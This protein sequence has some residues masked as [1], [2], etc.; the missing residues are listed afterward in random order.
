V[1]DE[2]IQTVKH[3]PY[4]TNIIQYTRD[5]KLF[6]SIREK[7]MDAQYD[8][9]LDLQNNHRS[10][11]LL[12]P[13]KSKTRRF[14]KHDFEKW[15]LVNLKIN[16]MYNFPPIPVRYSKVLPKLKLDDQGLDLFLPEN[17]K[18]DLDPKEKYIGFCPASKHYT[19][20]WPYDYFEELGEILSLHKYRIV[21][22]GGRNDKGICDLIAS[23]IPGSIN[24]CNDNELY[25]TA[26]NMK[27]CHAII[28]NDSGLM[29]V[30]TAIKVPVVAIFGSTVT[31]FGFT[32]YKAKSDVV[33]VENLKCRPC[34]HIGRN[35]CPQ[36]HFHCML[37][38][39]PATVYLQ[40]NH[41]LVS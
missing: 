41:L 7:I 16:L 33:Q 31:E 1:L 40:L 37:R 24:L 8:L 11:K 27:Q 38:I 12:E 2:L 14:E 18:P 22:F 13:L 23:S 19:K 17:I 6:S 15:M 32:P 26:I 34:S 3:N 39:T 25:K 29:H 10:H 30:A 4:I 36:K 21:V 9:V 35:K 20:M 5:E 28:C